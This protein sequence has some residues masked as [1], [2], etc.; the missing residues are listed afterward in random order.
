MMLPGTLVTPPLSQWPRT[1]KEF[2][3]FLWDVIKNEIRGKFQIIMM[4]IS[5]KKGILK[6]RR[7]K[8]NNAQIILTAKA[9]H[10]E[11]AEAVAAGNTDTINKICVKSLAIPLMATVDQRPKSQRYEWELVRY[12]GWRNPKIVSQVLAPVAV[13]KGAP[14]VRQVVVRIKSRQR[15][16]TF[17][18]SKKG[19]WEVKPGSQQETDLVE[20]M[21]MVSV[22]NPNTWT[23]S[24][25]R[26]MGSI[27]PTSYED[28][29]MEMETLAAV[30]AEELKNY[31]L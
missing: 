27:Q 22:V 8:L 20:H 15:R 3:G 13:T 28:W 7:F 4:S 6:P 19:S 31:K 5:S 18:R 30:E 23:S 25:W 26:I 11:M 24:E 10:R 2:F 12:N 9:M 21:V 1:R 14:L 16:T 29:R 17:E